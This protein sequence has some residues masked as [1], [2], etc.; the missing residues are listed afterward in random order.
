MVGGSCSPFIAFGLDPEG[1]E[2]PMKGLEPGDNLSPISIN[3]S[4]EDAF[5]ARA[6]IKACDSFNSLN[7]NWSPEA[8][9]SCKKL[10]A[11]AKSRP[12]TQVVSLH[13]PSPSSGLQNGKHTEEA[14]L[15]CVESKPGEHQSGKV[16]REPPRRDSSETH[17]PAC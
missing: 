5:S 17:L 6:G 12:H 9:L 8:T 7:C 1:S 4:E 10:V 2:E 3:H 16:G 11:A 15:Y 14:E 13:T